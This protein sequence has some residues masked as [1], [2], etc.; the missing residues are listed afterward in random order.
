MLCVGREYGKA[1]YR[2]LVADPNIVA[3][4]ILTVAFDG[5]LT[6]LLIYAIINNKPWRHFIQITLCI[7]ELYGGEAAK[8]VSILSTSNHCILTLTRG[9]T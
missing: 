6:M 7:C 9:V 2:W 3:L 8:A 4:E 5:P 1:D